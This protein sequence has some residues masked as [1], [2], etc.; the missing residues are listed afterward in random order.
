MADVLDLMSDPYTARDIIVTP[1]FKER[2]DKLLLMTHL[3]NGFNIFLLPVKESSIIVN[4]LSSLSDGELKYLTINIVSETSKQ[5]L[6]NLL[7]Y[8]T[9]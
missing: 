9:K 3:L 8:R 4:Y 5:F 1:E 6:V 7:K 2:D